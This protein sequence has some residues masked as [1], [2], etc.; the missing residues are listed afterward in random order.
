M[1]GFFSLFLKPHKIGV[2]PYIEHIDEVED[3]S[4]EVEESNETPIIDANP[5][6]TKNSNKF[7]LLIGINYISNKSKNDDLNGCVNDMYNLCEFL[8]NDCHFFD[9]QIIVLENKNASYE[10]IMIELGTLVYNS[11]KFPGSEIWFSYSGHGTSKYSFFEKD[12]RSEV[13]C[14][15]DY[16]DSGLISDVWLQENFIRK[17]HKDTKLFVLMDCC[18]SGSNMNLP[19]CLQDGMETKREHDYDSSNLCNII[20]ISGCRDD[21]TSADYYDNNDKEFQGALTNEFLNLDYR[22]SMVTNIQTIVRN[23]TNRGFSQRPVLSFSNEKCSQMT[24]I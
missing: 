16:Q 12:N 22:S 5:M 1:G 6:F 17:L 7:A 10:N 9:E 13:I 14:P 15:S 11:N 18:N 3:I 2:S 8:Q 19:Y 4:Y 20:K 21:Q 24:L 23:L